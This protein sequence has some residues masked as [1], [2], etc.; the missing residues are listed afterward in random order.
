MS[1]KK[2]Y[3]P[4]FKYTKIN[5]F[6]LIISDN[7]SEIC[8]IKDIFLTNVILK[9]NGRIIISEFPIPLFWWQYANHEDPERNAGFI[10]NVDIRKMNRN[11]FVNILS[12]NLSN[13]ISSNYILKISYSN[14]FNSYLYSINAKIKVNKDCVWTVTHNPSNGEIEYLDFYPDGAFR[15]DPCLK[16]NYNCCV[17]E[18]SEGNLIYLPHYHLELKKYSN[19][20]FNQ[21]SKFYYLLEDENPVIQLLNETH[22][23]TEASICSYM[24]DVH[25]GFRCCKD[26]SNRILTENDGFRAEFNI[27]SISKKQGIKILEKST[28]FDSIEL[29]NIPIYCSGINDFSKSVLDVPNKY[30]T[31]P[32]QSEISNIVLNFKN[33][34]TFL[35]DR[36]VGFSDS[37]SL[38]IIIKNNNCGRWIFTAL[39]PDFGNEDFPLNKKYKLS[40]K[41]K[42][43]NS[44]DK[45]FI[46]IGLRIH[47]QNE[48]DIFNINK[49][50]HYYSDKIFQSDEMIDGEWNDCICM[51][52][53]ISSKPDRVHLLLEF[54]GVGRCWFDDVL[55][56]FI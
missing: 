41:V 28:K 3:R 5:D 10:E 45:S 20:Q 43:W 35:W 31:W 18:N 25:F 29:K 21:L 1:Y 50:E 24:W 17:Y 38:S 32:W 12:R 22:L 8:A 46:S 54:H 6:D 33:S 52:N 47:F 40:A 2:I 55:F 53:T 30:N 34:A 37:N 56:E 51:T 15:K 13:S 44:D 42:L 36:E 39:G 19:L 16:K 4:D 23:G 26:Y 48:G 14:K 27:Y 9:P 7:G 11:I 49:Y